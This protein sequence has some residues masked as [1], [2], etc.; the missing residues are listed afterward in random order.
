MTRKTCGGFI[1]FLYL[2]ECKNVA[3]SSGNMKI[4]SESRIGQR[5]FWKRKFCGRVIS[6]FCDLFLARIKRTVN[7]M[8]HNVPTT[9]MASRNGLANAAKGEFITIIDRCMTAM[10]MR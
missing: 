6:P 7:G 1:I 9:M 4:I 8:I 3:I 2:A 5:I 10:Q